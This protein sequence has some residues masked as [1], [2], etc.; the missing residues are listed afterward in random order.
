MSDVPSGEI[1]IPGY[2]IEEDIERFKE[3][4]RKA[5][6]QPYRLRVLPPPC[7]VHKNRRCGYVPTYPEGTMA[8][9]FE[10]FR[11]AWRAVGVAAAE[12]ILSLFDKT[13]G[14]R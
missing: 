5:Q 1:R 9:A 12:L 11:H 10:D 7:S 14:G 4:F 8:R 3:A 6:T 13:V 2:V